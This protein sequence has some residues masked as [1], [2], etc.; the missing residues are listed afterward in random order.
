MVAV[1]VALSTSDLDI[2]AHQVHGLTQGLRVA[3]KA[4]HSA[5]ES[6]NLWSFVS[7]Q[8]QKQSRPAVSETTPYT[9]AGISGLI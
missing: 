6:G 2:H 8:I 5:K 1:D 7:G 3:A 4:S 9:T